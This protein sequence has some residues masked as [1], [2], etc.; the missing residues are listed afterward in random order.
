MKRIGATI[1][2]MGLLY[3]C[4]APAAMADASRDVAKEQANKAMVMKAYQELFGD[5][6]LSTLDRNFREDY[7]QHNPTIPSGREALRQGLLALGFDKMPKKA[8][9]FYRVAADGDLVWIYT[10]V[11]FGKGET[12]VV[13]IFRVQDGKVAEHWDVIQPI[14]AKTVSGNSMTDDMK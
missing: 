10:T 9:K 5:H 12:A 2:S 11:N 14:P 8:V 13:D 6:D 3:A 7:L 4:C 1:V